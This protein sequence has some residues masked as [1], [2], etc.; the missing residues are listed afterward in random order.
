MIYKISGGS[1]SCYVISPYIEQEHVIKLTPGIHDYFS[2]DDPGWENDLVIEKLDVKDTLKI[3]FELDSGLK[4][5]AHTCEEWEAIYS[6]KAGII[7][8]S[9]Y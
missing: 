1:A 5:I 4:M 2:D 9:E 7:C 3:N 8:Q 6:H